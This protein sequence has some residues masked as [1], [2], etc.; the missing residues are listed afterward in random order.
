[1]TDE[2]R[3]DDEQPTAGT[4]DFDAF[5]AEQA[6]TRARQTFTLY[7]REYTLPD[8]LPIMFTL[9]VE[10]VQDSSD[11][12][13]VRKMLATLF[14]GNTLDVWAEHGMTN[15]QFGTVLIYAAGN[16]R[17]PGSVSMARA[18]ELH[19]NQEQARAEG[20]EPAAPNRAA[21]RAK[22]KTK[23]RGSSGRR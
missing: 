12:E 2:T 19:D 7:G 20:K 23:K 13:D 10:R 17:S 15:R 8:S 22:P 5:F 16:V 6:T 14:G 1:M 3:P 18:A 21:R 11:P 9:Q 4:A